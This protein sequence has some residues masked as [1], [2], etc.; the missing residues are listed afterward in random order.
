[1]EASKTVYSMHA[2]SKYPEIEAIAAM[3]KL[4]SR[5]AYFERLDNFVRTAP[6]LLDA[7]GLPRDDGEWN[8]FLRNIHVL[9]ELLAGIGSTAMREEAGKIV[10]W[11]K[12]KDGKRC[13]DAFFSLST[14]AKSLCAKLEDARS[15]PNDAD[16]GRNPPEVRETAVGPGG[17]AASMRAPGPIHPEWIEKLCRLIDDFETEEAMAALHS[18]AGAARGAEM[19]E[20]LAAMRGALIRHDHERASALGRRILEAIRPKKPDAAP[21]DRKRILAVDDMPAILDAVK[22][23]LKDAYTVYGVS[24]PTAAL[25]FLACRSADLI[26]LDIEM[27]DMNGFDLLG[28]IR[29]IPAYEKTPILFFTGN[30]SEENVMRSLAGG[31]TDFLKKP[32]DS[33]ALLARI[34]KHIG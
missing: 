23:I 33:R 26:L 12:A 15:D 14:K 19:D 1:M 27:P 8:V 34:Q 24:S 3:E 4:G 5:N 25:K 22:S 32:I 31:A 7:P 2:L 9:R 17:G 28:I 10:E 29:R 13:G 11:A 20:A 21:A 18:L 30:S 6:R 16:P